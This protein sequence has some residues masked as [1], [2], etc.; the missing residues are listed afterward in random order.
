MRHANLRICKARRRL[1]DRSLDFANPRT[2]ASRVIHP[3]QT[4]ADMHIMLKAA[5]GS[6]CPINLDIRSAS[7]QVMIDPSLL[8][9]VILEPRDQCARRDADG[10][11]VTITVESVSEVD[12]RGK[13]GQFVLI[14]VS[15][16]GTAFL[17]TPYQG[18]SSRFSPRSRKGKEPAWALRWSTK[19]SR[20][21]A[22]TC[23]WNPPGKRHSFRIFLPRVSSI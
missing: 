22:A 17:Q 19:S 10:G 2:G 14:S 3:A 21:L 8:E 20:T 1:G 11:T 6:K 7:G 4:I 5:V 13:S 15:D 12:D 9:R 18:S 16:E 23:A